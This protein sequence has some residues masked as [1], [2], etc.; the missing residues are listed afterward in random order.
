MSGYNFTDG[1]R[2]VLQ[3]SREEAARLHHDHV[4]T[5]HLLLSIMREGD[6]VPAAM[7]AV[8]NV[9]PND[10]VSRVEALIKPGTADQTFGPDLPYTSRAKKVLEISMSEAREMAHSHVGSEHL[11]LGLLRE[12]TGITA[13]VLAPL[14]IHI[15]QARA[16]V[17][18][19]VGDRVHEVRSSGH[20]YRRIR[21]VAPRRS[22]I[23]I[24]GSTLLLIAGIICSSSGVEA[25]RH[26]PDW[27]GKVVGVLAIAAGLVMT[28]I[29]LLFGGRR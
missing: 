1:V 12:E 11:F 9:N 13:Q 25:F 21:S 18:R 4:G 3:M 8:L 16:E 22:G 10:V 28:L 7:M 17:L 27:I 14:G 6:G 26:A 29:R 5:E 23:A 20:N 24:R 15:D 2:K 19:L